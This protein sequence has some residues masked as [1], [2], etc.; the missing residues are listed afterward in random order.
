MKCM[1]WANTAA[2]TT[3]FFILWIVFCYEPFVYKVSLDH[4]KL[5]SLFDNLL[6]NM[7]ACW[8][9]KFR[10][11]RQSFDDRPYFGEPLSVPFHTSLNAGISGAR[12]DIKKRSTVFFPVFLYFHIKK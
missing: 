2:L 3:K 11:F 8:R 1:L 10:R 7:Q 6:I 12:K 5:Y 4:Y 9:H